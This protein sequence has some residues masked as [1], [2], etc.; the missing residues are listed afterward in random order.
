MIN[1]PNYQL[2]KT[3]IV[4]IFDNPIRAGSPDRQ[5]EGVP[6]WAQD[7]NEIVARLDLEYDSTIPG[8]FLTLSTEDSAGS[9]LNASLQIWPPAGGGGNV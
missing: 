7:L 6:E 8:L 4:R 5:A 3:A 1:D 2:P 9:P